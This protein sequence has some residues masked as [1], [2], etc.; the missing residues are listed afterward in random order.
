MIL[1]NIILFSIC[2]PTETLFTTKKSKVYIYCLYVSNCY[3]TAQSFVILGKV[4]YT[5][6]RTELQ[7]A[8]CVLTD[9]DEKE[10]FSNESN[11]WGIFPV[12][13]SL[14]FLLTQAS[15]S[16]IH[17]SF[18]FPDSSGHH[19]DEA[20]DWWP[21]ADLWWDIKCVL[22]DVRPRVPEH[23]P[24]SL[25]SDTAALITHPC[26]PLQRQMVTLS[27]QDTLHNTNFDVFNRTSCNLSQN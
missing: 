12:P 22:S 14:Y 2:D 26:R 13:L 11:L 15:Y 1:L 18:L 16:G 6:S 27:C 9:S 10:Y 3:F 23:H 24:S 8:K 25:T 19:S 17:N 4:E 5:K 7:A 20:Y 21:F